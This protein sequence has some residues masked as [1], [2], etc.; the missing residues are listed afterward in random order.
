MAEAVAKKMSQANANMQTN[1]PKKGER[2]SCEKCGMEVQVT[3]DCKCGSEDHLHFACCGQEM[4][5]K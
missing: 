1:P 2:Y 4:A 3:A 5:K